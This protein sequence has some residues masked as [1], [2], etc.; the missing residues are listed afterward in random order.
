MA[1]PCADLLPLLSLEK[2]RN[3]LGNLPG[4]GS[5]AAGTTVGGQVAPGTA[6]SP[7]RGSRFGLQ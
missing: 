5:S 7:C 2:L 4:A 6:C 1:G 3:V